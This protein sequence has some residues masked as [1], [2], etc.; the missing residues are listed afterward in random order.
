MDKI[1]TILFNGTSKLRVD[2]NKKIVIID[3]SDRP[4][5]C[6]NQDCFSFGWIGEVATAGKTVTCTV[7]IP[8]KYDI[9]KG[10]TAHI[11]GGAD[12]QLTINGIVMTQTAENV[13]SFDM[14]LSDST[15]TF[16]FTDLV[17]GNVGG[18]AC[19]CI[20]VPDNGQSPPVREVQLFPDQ[21]TGEDETNGWSLTYPSNYSQTLG[22]VYGT[23]R[24]AAGYCLFGLK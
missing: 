2:G 1:W 14:P 22:G 17:G 4:C 7:T 10:L 11:S 23:N 24:F 12:D 16:D 18:G 3:S 13:V 19:I 9:T 5:C 6:Q 15:I 20:N 21:A 8:K